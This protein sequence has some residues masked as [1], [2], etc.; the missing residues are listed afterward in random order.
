MASLS[1][2]LLGLM[3]LNLSK[4]FDYYR[5]TEKVYQ[6][7]EKLFQFRFLTRLNPRLIPTIETFL[8]W[9]L[10]GLIFYLTAWFLFSF[11]GE[12]GH[13]AGVVHSFIFPR[14]SDR[15]RYE[16]AILKR[17]GIRLAGLAMASLWFIFL[18]TKV[19]PACSVYF[20]EAFTY[21]Q[22]PEIIGK[23]VVSVISLAL[24]L[25]FIAPILRMVILKPRVFS[26]W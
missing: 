16:L 19:V 21:M 20:F 7:N 18:F 22:T 5:N 9:S 26:D 11:F 23:A 12:A 14:K 25:Y 1:L 4:F 10:I 13:D 8:V 6:T 17:F 2:S 24:Y 3:I 15:Q